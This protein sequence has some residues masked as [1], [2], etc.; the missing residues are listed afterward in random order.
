MIASSCPR[1]QLFPREPIKL[2]RRLDFLF[3]KM[4]HRNLRFSYGSQN[5]F[6]AFTPLSQ[7]SLVVAKTT[8]PSRNR[9]A[10][11][12]VFVVDEATRPSRSR[13]DYDAFFVVD[14][15]TRPSL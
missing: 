15:A 5:V 14:E 11:D 1:C 6:H 9:Q 13:Q 7:T 3:R 4:T 12:A 8:T 2:V 10:Y